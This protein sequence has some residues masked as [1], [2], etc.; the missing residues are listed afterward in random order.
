MK[1]IMITYIFIYFIIGLF[2]ISSFPMIFTDEPWLGERAYNLIAEGS[3]KQTSF[4]YSQNYMSFYGDIFLLFNALA[5]KLFGYNIF[6]LRLFPL[7]FFT[8]SLVL[9]YLLL[10]KIFNNKIGFVS[11]VLLSIHPFAINAS[12]ISRKESV[13]IFFILLGMYLY[14][15]FKDDMKPKKLFF[16]GL[17][18]SIPILSH[19]FGAV[20]ILI[21]FI[22]LIFNLQ[23]KWKQALK[24]SI[25]YLLGTLPVLLL[26]LYN[27]INNK[28]FYLE[29]AK[30]KGT[31]A[32]SLLLK[33]KNHIL[34]LHDGFDLS[35]FHNWYLTFIL[36]LG[37]LAIVGYKKNMSPQSKK[38]YIPFMVI[39]VVVNIFLL[40][41]SNFSRLYLIYI[42]LFG[43]LLLIIPLYYL[44]KKKIILSVIILSLG[45]LFIY[46]DYLWVNYYKD[47]N[48]KSF[49]SSLKQ[50]I[51]LNSNVLGKINY[52]LS[53]THCKYF[54][55]E[56]LNEF[57]SSGGNFKDYIDKYNIQYI[58]YDYSWDYY[59]NSDEIRS[60]LKNNAMLISTT[61]DKY[62]SN[63]IGPP[64]ANHIN[65]P[66]FNLIDI[67]QK[68]RIA[69]KEY[70]TKVYKIKA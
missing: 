44:D 4:P 64:D 66:Y 60:Y 68:N 46:Q 40:L 43:L 9:L 28:R 23:P 35:L 56:D 3:L 70:W 20:S 14:F 38:G 54:A 25:Y 37:I 17:I 27:F 61:E 34:Y 67:A 50:S 62:Y 36:I 32:N 19:A 29:H 1:K 65:L 47:L 22:L 53:F 15:T 21:G 63:R 41:L 39:F 52:Q 18:F 24:E 30:L 48:Y 26:F 2:T 12:R 6:A 7:I 51:P 59:Q 69:D 58:I 42:L 5:I 13:I 16:L 57:L 8:S 10:T 33:V 11:V 55:T 31:F 49:E 45:T